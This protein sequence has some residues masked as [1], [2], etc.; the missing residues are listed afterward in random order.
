MWRTV[1][2][3]ENPAPPHQDSA[4]PQ[5]LLPGVRSVLP[6]EAAVL[7]TH[8]DTRP[9]VHDMQPVLCNSSRGAPAL[10]LH[11]LGQRAAGHRQL[12]W[13]LEDQPQSE[14]RRLAE[15]H[16]TLKQSSEFT[17]HQIRLEE[18][19][20]RRREEDPAGPLQSGVTLARETRRGG[21]GPPVSSEP[22]G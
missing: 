15:D 5:V 4:A 9:Q 19:P 3:L 10:P 2:H 8:P 14:R 21:R 7:V 12:A 16:P 20:E 6:P 18:L 22:H 17:D 13:G 1:L 11:A